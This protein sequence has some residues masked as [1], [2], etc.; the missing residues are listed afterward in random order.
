MVQQYENSIDHQVPQRDTEQIGTDLKSMLGSKDDGFSDNG[1][2]EFE[3]MIDDMVYRVWECGRCLSMGHK[4]FYCVKEIRCRACFSYGHVANKCLNKN[5]RKAQ[6]WVPKRINAT[7]SV[8]PQTN[9]TLSSSA[10]SPPPRPN[11]S[12]RTTLLPP[13]LPSPPPTGPPSMAVFELDPTPWLPLGHQI[14]DG[15]PARLPRTYYSPAVAPPHRH[16]NFCVAYIKPAQPE[17]NVFWGEQ[18]R[19][20]ETSFRIL[21]A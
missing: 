20:L 5:N 4:A 2:R 6:I 10:G 14:L 21:L 11:Q 9:P 12:T 16:D 18:V 3:D 13:P 8:I 19:G 1:L 7:D 15:G 17:G